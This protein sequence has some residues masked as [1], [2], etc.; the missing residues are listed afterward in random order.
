MFSRQKLW[1]VYNVPEVSMKTVFNPN[2]NIYT[3]KYDGRNL[4][5]KWNMF[6]CAYLD[7]V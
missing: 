1:N 6:H 4:T 2:P 5:T 7:D 3:F